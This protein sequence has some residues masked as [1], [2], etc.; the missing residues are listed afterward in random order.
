MRLSR[1]PVRF[2]AFALLV[3]PALALSVTTG[4]T[5][6]ERALDSVNAERIQA[7][8]EFI[9]S[10]ELAGRDTPSEGLRTCARFLRSRLVRLGWQPG[11]EDGYFHYYELANPRIDEAGTHA[12]LRLGG[13]ERPLAYGDDYYFYSLGV[14]DLSLFGGVVYCGGGDKKELAE[15]DLS[16]KWALCMDGREHWK[17]RERYARKAGA[18]GV[19]VIAGED[20]EDEPYDTRF[21]RQLANAESGRV[22]WPSG[23]D[24]EP[25]AVFPQTF[26][27]D[28]IARAVFPGL[29]GET[30]PAVGTELAV[31]FEETRALAGG[32]LAQLENV[33]GFWPGEGPLANEVILLSAHYDHV[34]A[35]G[36][37]VFN[38]A[39]D[40]G[41]GTTALLAV[42]E[43]LAEY[44]PMRRSVM[45]I[46]VSG[47]EKGLYGSRAWTQDPWLPEGCVPVCNIN[48][49][50]VGRNA[51]DYLLITPTK[52]RDEYNG[53]TR[54]AEAA[55]P[56]EGFAELGSADSYWSRSDHANFAQNLDIPVAF[57]FSDVHEDYHKATDTPDKIDADK[58][59][60]VVRVLLRMLEGL[61]TDTLS[62]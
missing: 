39:D 14:G 9:A 32:G 56:L 61:Q 50:M 52:A 59:R 36:D 40:N 26:L 41:S 29:F 38:G 2:A 4:G 23:K 19:L 37:D 3:L 16:G 8:V 17:R 44:G 49:D 57:L 55:A 5:S 28:T 33:C 10:D 42:A 34:G 53:L 20:Y 25:K 58:I 43:A 1:L 11:A 51:P 12:T 6:L 62:L 21:T 45:L 35:Q 15:L 47:E 13:D 31:T 24:G 18:L 22:S 46:W 60:R 48:V 27:S 30:A 54:L 7:D